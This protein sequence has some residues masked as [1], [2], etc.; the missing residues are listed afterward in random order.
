MSWT[1]LSKSFE[2]STDELAN[3]EMNRQI[4][5]VNLKAQWIDE[6]ASLLPLIENVLASGI[7]VGGEDVEEF[8]TAA[9]QLCG[10][11][12][13]VALNS[14]TDAL[15]C[16]MYAMGIGLGDEVITTPNSFIASAASIVQVGATPVFVDV[17]ADQNINVE[18]I[19][20]AVTTKT[21]A[22]MPVHLTGR[23]ANMSEILEIG[24]NHNLQIVE[25]AAQAIG[26]RYK[27]QPSGSFGDAG[28][29]STHP[30]KNL[31]ACGDG[32]FVATND[33]E[34]AEKIS[35]RRN[36]GLIDRNRVD[37][38]GLVSRMDTLQAVVLRYR[39]NRLPNVI[40]KRRRNAELYTDVLDKQYVYIASEKNYEFNTYHTFVIQ[41]DNRDN[42]REYLSSHGIGTAIHYPVTIHQ[43]S[44]LKKLGYK[45]GDFPIA[46]SQANRI[47]T[48]PVN[49]YMT[50]E[51]VV[52]VADQV[53]SFF[54]AR[55]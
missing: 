19:E 24:K 8:E 26:S 41:V 13:V 17:S 42:L 27:G 21:R 46:E 29:F 12:H 23:I 44:A 9:A 5:Y 15:S 54:H 55:K 48:L 6:R 40:Q 1:T 34:I 18:L 14:G 53:N 52:Y 28:C 2:N 22:I 45:L 10:V 38:F 20:S 30:L 3:S 50:E 47:L 7:Y 37:D 25:D 32:G 11:Q 4:P 33:K 31:N 36:H 39:L 51:E 16:A 43:Q 35:L 49:Q